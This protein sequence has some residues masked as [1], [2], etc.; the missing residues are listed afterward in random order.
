LG[1]SCARARSR[2]DQ[3]ANNLRLYL[4]EVGRDIVTALLGL[5]DALAAQAAQHIA[6]VAPG[7][8]HLQPAQPI[9]FAH[10]LLAHAQAF[11][12]DAGRM[13]DW[14]GAPRDRRSA[15]PRSPAPRS[16]FT[17]ELTAR[18][19]GFDAPCENSIDAVGARDHVAEFLFVTAMLASTCRGSPRRS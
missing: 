2:N 12:R 11:T 9:V 7:F 14:T 4:R 16:P 18:E 1:G 17:P 3:A 10:L 15:P 5:Q 19:L 8:T 6:T 13:I